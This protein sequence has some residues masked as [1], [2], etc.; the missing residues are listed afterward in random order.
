MSKRKATPKPKP[1]KIDEAKIR[2]SHIKYAMERAEKTL[3]SA[4]IVLND[5]KEKTM[6]MEPHTLRCYLDIL[7][8]TIGETHTVVEQAIYRAWV[9]NDL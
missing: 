2:E 7:E 6:E 3:I 8:G 1:V 9:D 4:F 5:L